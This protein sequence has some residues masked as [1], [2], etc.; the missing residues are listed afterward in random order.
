MKKTQLNKGMKRRVMYVESKGDPI[1][2][3]HGHIG[4]VTFSK[5]GKTVYYKDK[6]LER[7]TQ[8]VAGNFFDTATG[9]EYWISGVKMRGSNAHPSEPIKVVID[10]DAVD[11]YKKIIEK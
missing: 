1:A 6:V 10:E 5:S 7:T 11:E 3:A 4:W 8:A 9:E 2:G